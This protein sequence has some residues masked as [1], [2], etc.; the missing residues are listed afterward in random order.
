M[1]QPL[2][3][4]LISRAAEVAEFLHLS[5]EIQD[6]DYSHLERILSDLV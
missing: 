5:L 1:R 3:P 4:D 6:A 2:D